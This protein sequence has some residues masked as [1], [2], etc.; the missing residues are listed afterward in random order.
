MKITKKSIFAIV[1][2]ALFVIAIFMMFAPF[3]K[4]GSGDYT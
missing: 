3:L 2:A 1:E 4:A